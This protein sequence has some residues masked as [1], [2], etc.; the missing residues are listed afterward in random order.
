MQIE[1][2]D[3]NMWVE[4]Y[5]QFLDIIFRFFD[6][7]I[8][9]LSILGSIFLSA[10]GFP[11]EIITFIFFLTII[12]IVTKHL[13]IVV[14]NYG[15]FSLSNYAKA[16]QDR[17]LTS[18]QLKNSLCIKIILYS[19]L[20]YISHQ[21]SI[22]DGILLGKE[23]SCVLYNAIILIEISSILESFIDMGLTGL[24]PILDFIKNMQTQLF[25][26]KENKK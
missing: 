14:V 21:L 19:G 13:S 20:L 22:I 2:V 4:I 3:E 18:R 24:K 12:D 5:Q 10:I 15:S 9:L 8:I 6:K 25:I 17:Y 26:K 7:G 23:I 1:R 11:K 16:W